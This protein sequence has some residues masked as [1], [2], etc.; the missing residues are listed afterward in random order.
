MAAAR[1][2]GLRFA[3]R[4]KNGVTDGGEIRSDSILCIL[5]LSG[6]ELFDPFEKCDDLEQFLQRFG[7]GNGRRHR[8]R[9]FHNSD[10][11]APD[12]GLVKR[13]PSQE[14]RAQSFADGGEVRVAVLAR[15]KREQ[16][17][18]ALFSGGTFAWRGHGCSS[19]DVGGEHRGGGGGV[20]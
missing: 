9:F 19:D 10:F 16:R 14:Q 3:I 5:P 2:R 17:Y 6:G 12:G 18:D 4:S 7:G 15:W 20:P 13:D 1:S 8:I 11:R